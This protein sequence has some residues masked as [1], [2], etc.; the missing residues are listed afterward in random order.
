ML[1]STLIIINIIILELILS[2][3][4][5]AVLATLVR[6]LPHKQQSK[7]L[8]YGIVGAYLFR[9][10][11]LVFATILIK[12]T[13]LKLVGGA[14]LIYLAYKALFKK[15]EDD[16]VIN[17][18]I[19]G[20]SIFWSTVVAAEILD[21]VFSIDNVFAVV[22]FS[23]NIWLI[24]LGVFIGI[25][26]MRLAATKFIFLLDKYPALEKVAYYVIAV[27]GIRLV[28]SFFFPLLNTELI[29][30]VFSLLTLLAFTI[31][32]LFKNH[33]K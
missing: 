6:K 33:L 24:C 31:P 9:G 7:A 14:Y 11:A 2:I 30:I 20:L 19:P 26:A 28:L 5:A 25:L 8:T 32:I 23:S 16:D 15:S 10:L 27:L 1:T 12:I 29:D 17:I 4:N 18:H 22:A 3:D 21:L 13:W